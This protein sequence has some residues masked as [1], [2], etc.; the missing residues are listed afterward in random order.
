MR[1]KED[2]QSLVEFALALPL[3]LL[4]LVGVIDFGRV[5]YTHLQMELVTQEAVRL[6]GL[7]ESDEA[8]RTY[9][10]NQFHVGDASLLTV[11]ISPA[12]TRKSGTYVTV[13]LVYPEKLFNPLGDYAVP[14]KVKTSSMIRVE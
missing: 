5:I 10:K 13:E 6:G 4:L 11:N 2:G 12:G 9:A 8:I 14:Y 3:I 7:G 1:K